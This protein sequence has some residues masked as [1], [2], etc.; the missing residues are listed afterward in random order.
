[1]VLGQIAILKIREIDRLKRIAI[2]LNRNPE[3]RKFN[4]NW[5]RKTK[6]ANNAL[7]EDQYWTSLR[8]E[9]SRWPSLRGG[10]TL[11]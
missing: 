3:A 1:M 2:Y 9:M 8:A 6:S 10:P 7:L 11:S 5:G 4:G